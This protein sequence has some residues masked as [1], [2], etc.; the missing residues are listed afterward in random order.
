M[1]KVFI[2]ITAL[3]LA[4]AL[5]AC[6]GNG[7]NPARPDVK[8]EIVQNLS[9]EAPTLIW[10][11]N[12]PLTAGDDE[13][14]PLIEWMKEGTFSFDYQAVITFGGS[15]TIS[16][17]RLSVDG[18][19]VCINAVEAA[20][21]GTAKDKWLIF[22]DDELYGIE[23][24]MKMIFPMSSN[25]LFDSALTLNM[26]T[27]F[28]GIV[29]AGSGTGA[30]EGK[31]LPYEEY[32]IKDIRPLPEE[33]LKPDASV[34]YYMDGGRVYGFETDSSGYYEKRIVMIVSNPKNKVP[35][36]V[37]DL[38]KNYTMKSNIYE[39]ILGR[40]MNGYDDDYDDY[41]DDWFGL[42]DL[43]EFIQQ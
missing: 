29:H 22:K 1:K 2:S 12:F 21:G 43:V 24:S 40:Y 30:I 35:A 33:C 16:K 39:E 4:C 19:N 17:G 10:D 28:R 26:I 5:A 36:G 14:A 18:D 3:A 15:T 7:G 23:E 42:D 13:P 6:G 41:D 20:N 8:S 31:T 38:P 34:K 27:D 25:G 37:F 32:T 9:T 11:D